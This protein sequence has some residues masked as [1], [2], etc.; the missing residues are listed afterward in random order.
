MISAE[1]E[2]GHRHNAHI[3]V[4]VITAIFKY[5]SWQLGS[6]FREMDICANLACQSTIQTHWLMCF[7]WGFKCIIHSDLLLRFLTHSYLMILYDTGH[8]G[9]HW[10][11]LQAMIT[12]TDNSL[13]T[14]TDNLSTTEPLGT[15]VGELW[16][17]TPS[18]EFI[19]TNFKISSA[20]C[21]TF[22]SDHNVCFTA[23]DP[24]WT[25]LCLV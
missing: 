10:F 15:I 19:E 13:T 9:R 14:V 17:K 22:Y 2:S 5:R 21:R 8:L 4:T 25:N 16:I 1:L 7:G 3:S 6:Y 11:R 23:E 20:K 18:Y 24:S 12:W